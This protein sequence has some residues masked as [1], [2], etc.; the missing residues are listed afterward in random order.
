MS[1]LKETVK[2]KE[3]DKMCACGCAN[4]SAYT[5]LHSYAMYRDNIVEELK[6]KLKQAF[7]DNSVTDAAVPA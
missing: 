3:G 5:R 7:D 1:K 6:R 2:I 4:L